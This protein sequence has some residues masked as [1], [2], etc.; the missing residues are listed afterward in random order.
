MSHIHNSNH[1][2]E[3]LW[4]D[5][6]KVNPDN[7]RKIIPESFYFCDNEKDANECA[8]LVKK[9]IKQ[10]TAGSLWW[11]EKQNEPLPEIGN[12][13][14]ITD[15]NGNATAIIEITKVEPTPFNKITP[16]F[17]Q[18]EGE[19]DKSLSYWKQVHQAY[20]KREMEPH[21]EHFDENMVI[22]CEHFKTIYPAQP[23]VIY[24]QNYFLKEIQNTDINDI[25]KGLSDLEITQF[26]AVHYPTLEATKEQ[27][28]WYANLKKTG[29]GLWWGIYDKANNQFCGAGGFND[30]NKIHQ[31]AEIGF[32]LLKEYWG[33]GIMKEVMPKLFELGF[34]T[35]GLNRIEGYVESKNTKC[36]SALEKINFTYEG[37]M[38]ECEIDNGKKVSVDIYSILKRE[39]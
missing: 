17:A 23:S 8:D 33:K 31:K 1:S 11:Y 35:L 7:P 5:F 12:Q 19:G 39:W 15:W 18:I 24:T 13:Y 2:V 37:T 16:E 3:K 10:A 27:M 25:F 38:R 14:I 20:Y 32:W 6:L 30:L 29:T 22:I 26:Y 21:Q 36:K 4:D 28:D 9:G 34:T